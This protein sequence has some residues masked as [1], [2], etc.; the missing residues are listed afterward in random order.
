MNLHEYQAKSLL[1]KKGLPV[2]RGRLCTTPAEAAEAVR[3]LQGGIN[4]RICVIKAQ[5][6]AGGRGRAGGIKVAKTPEEAEELARLMLGKTLLTAQT[7]KV[8]KVVK[9]VYVEEE[10]KITGEFYLSMLLERSK[11]C[12]L[13]VSSPAGG[14]EIEEAARKMPDKILSRPLTL[15]LGVESGLSE[16]IGLS[17]GFTAP[18]REQ[19]LKLLS[20][21]FQA[22][23]EYDCSL[24][25]INPLVLTPEEKLIVLDAKCVL[26]DNGLFRHPELEALR[27]WDQ[28]D[29]RDAAAQRLGLSY[30]GLDGSIGCLVNGAGLAM[31]TMDLIKQHGGEPANFL[32]VG[33]AASLESVREGFK[34]L[35]AD[36]KVKSILVNIFGGIVKCDLIA[37]AVVQAVRELEPRIPLVIR[38]QGTNVELG[39]RVLAESGLNIITAENMEQAAK[40]AVEALK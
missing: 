16:A 3:D 15:E 30:V 14:M 9:K 38:L 17:F 8:G 6:H 25:E 18:L 2:L 31:A 22:F 37:D 35:L 29:P 4:G 28:E 27:D 23:I 33:G 24:I 36:R 19:L 26:D 20:G 40:S 11:K 21:M 10:C 13:L 1:A 7:G 12:L 32:D 5:I 34:I 39:R